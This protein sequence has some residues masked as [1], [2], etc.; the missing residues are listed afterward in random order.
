MALAIDT[1]Y[2]E[3]LFTEAEK[4]KM[5]KDLFFT[6]FREFDKELTTVNFDKNRLSRLVVSSIIN[7]EPSSVQKMHEKSFELKKQLLEKGLKIFRFV[8]SPIYQMHDT[9][10]VV[11][12]EEAECY[13]TLDDEDR[14]LFEFSTLQKPE[15]DKKSIPVFG[16]DYDCDQHCFNKMNVDMVAKM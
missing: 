9:E 10:S 15:Q 11:Y 4:K 16:R 12:N 2:K 3:V 1:E 14:Q 5:I 13:E 6:T 8:V 7:I